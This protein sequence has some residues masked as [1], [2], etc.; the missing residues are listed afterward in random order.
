MAITRREL[1]EFKKEKDYIGTWEEKRFPEHPYLRGFQHV[2]AL[3][4]FYYDAVDEL[5]IHL[6]ATGNMICPCA[7]SSEDVYVPFALEED[8]KITFQEEDLKN[9]D[10][11]AFYMEES[12]E[13]EDILL[14]FLLPIAPIKV[15]KEGKIEYPSGDDWKVMTEAEFI[16]SRKKQRDSRWDKLLDLEMDKEEQ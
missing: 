6:Q 16:E 4:H 9:E 1:R 12:V 13:L 7:I 10:V 15:V 2:K 8:E 11:D 3:F 5:R 14:A